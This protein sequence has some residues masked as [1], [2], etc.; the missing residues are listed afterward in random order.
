[1]TER[2]DTNIPGSYKRP[3]RVNPPVRHEAS[4]EITSGKMPVLTIWQPWADSIIHGPKRVENRDWLPPRNVVMKRLA[5]HAAA[6]EPDYATWERWFDC[7]AR[8]R[9]Q[10]QYVPDLDRQQLV[11][12]CIVGTVIV[13]GHFTAAD[14]RSRDPWVGGSRYCWI[15][16]DPRPCVPIPVRGLQKLWGYDEGEVVLATAAWNAQQQAAK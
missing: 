4:E 14:D 1:M 11:R 5:I 7:A 16:T 8:A 6:R 13:V 10:G 9:A 15:L 2:P 3:P 12:G